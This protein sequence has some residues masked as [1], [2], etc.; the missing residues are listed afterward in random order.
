MAHFLVHFLMDCS[1]VVIMEETFRLR[2]TNS[3]N[4]SSTFCPLRALVSRKEAPIRLAAFFPSW[5]ETSLC[6]SRSLLLATRMV[7][8]GVVLR[9]WACLKVVLACSK[10]EREVRE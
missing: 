5:V 1:P 7:E 10:E 6:S 9:F 3:Q 8:K 4:A 2:R